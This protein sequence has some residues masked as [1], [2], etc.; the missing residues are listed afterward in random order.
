MLR[1]FLLT[2]RRDEGVRPELR[3]PWSDTFILDDGE[4]GCFT[5]GGPKRDEVFPGV[6]ERQSGVCGVPLAEEEPRPIEER[7]TGGAE[8]CFVVVSLVGPRSAGDRGDDDFHR[9]LFTG[10]AWCRCVAKRSD[11][12]GMVVEGC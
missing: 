12:G 1:F 2:L 6:T 3:D 9:G 10:T 7:K 5:D 4:F 11:C 8:E